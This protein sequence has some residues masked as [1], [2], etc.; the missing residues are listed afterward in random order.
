MIE[1]GIGGEEG[2]ADGE[3]AGSANRGHAVKDSL[4]TAFGRYLCDIHGCIIS[5]T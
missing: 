2:W 3:E 5:D 4:S 1:N